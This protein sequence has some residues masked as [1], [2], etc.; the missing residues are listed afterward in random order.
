MSCFFELN[1]STAD[2]RAPVANGADRIEGESAGTGMDPAADWFG[3][4]HAAS[5][6]NKFPAIFRI[7]EIAD[8]VAENP[9]VLVNLHYVA[10]AALAYGAACYLEHFSVARNIVLIGRLRATDCR[11]GSRTFGKV[12]ADRPD[13]RS[14]D[15]DYNWRSG[16]CSCDGRGPGRRRG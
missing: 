8:V 14:W 1:L 6:L 5:A 12:V 11:S 10:V 15:G 2:G 13:D 3:L 9:S 7:G 16:W 4:S